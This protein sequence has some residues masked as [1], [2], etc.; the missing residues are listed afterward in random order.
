MKYLQIIPAALL[1][2]VS[3][4]AF[5]EDPAFAQVP[6][7]KYVLGTSPFLARADSSAC[8]SNL[9]EM[10]LVTAHP[11]D[12]ID[13]YDALGM[14]LIASTAIPALPHD[15]AAARSRRLATPLATIKNWFWADRP[16]A[17]EWDSAVD[18]PAFLGLA[19]TQLRSSPRQPLRLIIVGSP[20]YVGPSEHVSAW[21]MSDG[22]VPSDGAIVAPVGET[23]FAIGPRDSLSGINVS[24]CY[25]HERFAHEQNRLACSRLWAL[26]CE[27]QGA[28]LGTFAASPSL[29]FERAQTDITQSCVAAGLDE[30]D[31]KVT[32][33]RKVIIERAPSPK[34]TNAV[35]S[36]NQHATVAPTVNRP[37][38][39]T[40]NQTPP[41]RPT[42]PVAGKISQASSSQG[43]NPAVLAGATS[44]LPVP[45]GARVGIGCVWISP[46]SD[47]PQKADL[48]LYVRTPEGEVLYYGHTNS[49]VG[50]GHYLRD[51]RS[52]AQT[53]EAN[54]VPAACEYIE[55]REMSDSDLRKLCC[56]INVFQGSGDKIHGLLQVVRGSQK[57][58]QSF[59]FET[60]IGNGG[61]D[62]EKRPSPFWQDFDVGALLLDLKAAQD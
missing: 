33:M 30:A 34:Q 36:S 8:F 50:S 39:S 29:A 24:F 17:S 32:L 61:T 15:N 23:P 51:V 49:R 13:V 52:A 11:G 18:F 62:R 54:D 2:V 12:E 14:N 60:P 44:L 25:L 46:G 43:E 31:S 41:Q 55:L 56:S 47:H 42:V 21:A 16:H 57:A 35:E 26:F 28:H 59:D 40:R 38:G 37:D 27:L 58:S 19:A 10:I 6:P 48:D 45:A 1:A 9:C 5:S 53:L 7:H 20:F 3:F 22:Y 4:A